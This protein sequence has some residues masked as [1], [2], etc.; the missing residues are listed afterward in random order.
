MLRF[1]LSKLK[2]L[3]IHQS[4]QKEAPGQFL[5]GSRNLLGSQVKLN[6]TDFYILPR[7]YTKG[8]DDYFDQNAHFSYAYHLERRRPRNQ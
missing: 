4:F 1:P 3:S 8:R 6:D 7:F 5:A 2:A